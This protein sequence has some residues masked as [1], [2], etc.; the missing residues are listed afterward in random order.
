M[1]PRAEPATFLEGREQSTEVIRLGRM[2]ESGGFG[3]PS[4]DRPVAGATF[5]PCRLE[6][7]AHYPAFALWRFGSKPEASAQSHQRT[8]CGNPGDITSCSHPR[9]FLTS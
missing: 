1:S 2:E 8:P 5:Y 3:K 4:R 7:E 6:A 9:A